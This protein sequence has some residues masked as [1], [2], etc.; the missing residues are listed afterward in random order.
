V[1]IY[2]IDLNTGSQEEYIGT[3]FQE[4]FDWTGL[5]IPTLTSYA[6]RGTYVFNVAHTDL[7]QVIKETLP[8]GHPLSACSSTLWTNEQYGTEYL[9]WRKPPFV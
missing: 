6:W 1:I 5:T 9:N 8:E 3:W 4:T 7:G 2:E